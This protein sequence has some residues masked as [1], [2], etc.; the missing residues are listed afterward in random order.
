MLGSKRHDTH[1]RARS[2]TVGELHGCALLDGGALQCWEWSDATDKSYLLPASVP[3]ITDAIAVSAGYMQTCVL[4]RGGS[5]R[6]WP[7]QTGS[8][9]V[10][11][12]G[13]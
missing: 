6:C 12:D 7:T 9:P 8:E 10:T 3:A 4:I 11:I 2:V 1:R 5:V 13:F